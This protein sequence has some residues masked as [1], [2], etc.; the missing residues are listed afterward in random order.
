MKR[1]VDEIRSYVNFD[2]KQVDVEFGRV[3]FSIGSG[4]HFERHCNISKS[5]QTRLASILNSNKTEWKNG[6]LETYIKRGYA[7]AFL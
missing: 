1:T 4:Y 2:K 7:G 6:R 5:S 3:H